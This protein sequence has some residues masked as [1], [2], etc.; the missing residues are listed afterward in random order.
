MS[1]NGSLGVGWS[2]PPEFSKN[3]GDVSLVSD[4]EDIRQSLE[5][6]F[7][8]A[9]NERLNYPDFGCDL[10]NF[11]FEEINNS[12]VTKLKDMISNAVSNY[13][14]RIGVISI[15]IDESDED[16]RLLLIGLEYVILSSESVQSFVYTFYTY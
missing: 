14:P 1:N 5:I 13:E 8:T 6:I 15:N 16:A 9:L 2:F 4:E 3:G 10:N 12:L 11:M 7:T